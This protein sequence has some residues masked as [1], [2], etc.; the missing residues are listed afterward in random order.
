MAVCPVCKGK[1]SQW[2]MFTLT[3][4]NSITCTECNT[5]LVANR[6]RN[7]LIGGL[8]A[9]IGAPLLLTSSKYGSLESFL[10][11]LIIWLIALTLAVNYF[12]KLEVKRT[13]TGDS[14][15]L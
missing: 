8:G 3:N 1:I 15:S 14:D 5:T 9:G 13:Q 11:A 12:N 7:S 2:K 4:F 6:T 10:V